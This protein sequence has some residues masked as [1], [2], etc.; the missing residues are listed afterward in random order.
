MAESLSDSH[1]EPGKAAAD[2]LWSGPSPLGWFDRI[3]RYVVLAT[4]LAAGLVAAG[5][6][7]MKVAV[8]VGLVGLVTSAVRTA[9]L[10][11]VAG[12]SSLWAFLVFGLQSLRAD[13]F[14]LADVILPALMVPLPIV[15]L[16]SIPAYFRSSAARRKAE[17][18]LA[19]RLEAD[20]KEALEA[21]KA[22]QRHD[23]EQRRLRDERRQ[24]EE[25]AS[26]PRAAAE[27]A[28]ALDEWR[29]WRRELESSPTG[30]RPDMGAY[31]GD[32][33]MFKSDHAKWEKS[34]EG[35]RY[36]YWRSTGDR[37]RA[38]LKSAEELGVIPGVSEADRTALF[39]EDEE[40]VAT[41]RGLVQK[42]LDD[43]PVTRG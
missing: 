25:A 10:Y 37:L 40:T 24:R 16:A 36:T 42:Y 23:E 26:K 19:A 17:A 6:T 29:V 39:S 31:Y 35:Q 5:S 41:Y 1:V 18:V 3:L 8:L 33:D 7:Y 11:R 38:A 2:A 34:P 28:R 32:F 4:G 30:G 12:L 9:G 27:L 14:H 43:D 20:E 22:K 21:R 13:E 15:L